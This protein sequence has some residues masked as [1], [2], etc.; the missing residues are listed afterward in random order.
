[1]VEIT[2]EAALLV[3]DGPLGDCNETLSPLNVKCVGKVALENLAGNFVL[4]PLSF[5]WTP[6]LKVNWTFNKNS[7]SRT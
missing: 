6:E 3:Q 2:T 1:M 4:R 5:S 7:Y